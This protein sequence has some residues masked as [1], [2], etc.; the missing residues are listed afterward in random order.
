MAEG[1][2]S[3]WRLMGPALLCGLIVA[4]TV[5]VQRP[6]R[7]ASDF[8]GHG[9]VGS[10]F[11]KAIEICPA[12]VSPAA[13]SAAGPALGLYMTPTLTADGQFLGDDSFALGTAPF[14]P[15]TGAHGQW[16]PTSATEFT[17]DYT[18]MLNTFPPVG[19][20]SVTALRFQWAGVVADKNT[21]QGFVNLYFQPGNTPVWSEL[22]GSQFPVL[23][24]TEASVLTVPGPF[25]KDPS[26]CKTPGCPL[27][28]KFT[29]KRVA[30]NQ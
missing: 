18:F 9:A 15:H 30:S 25:V 17:A 28:F 29:V 5:L 22:L 6:V 1:A 2:R 3:P 12:G 26:L 14:G 19:K 20:I 23:T 11:G 21:L 13:C 24:P 7:S 27:V 10:Y 8:S 16:F 4:A